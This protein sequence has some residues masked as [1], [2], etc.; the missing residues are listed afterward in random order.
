MTQTHLEPQVTKSASC[1]S[2]KTATKPKV[3]QLDQ[4]N[5]KPEAT[6]LSK[7]TNASTKGLRRTA[8]AMDLAMPNTPKRRKPLQQLATPPSSRRQN[9]SAR[10][11]SA[12]RI[13]FFE[14]QEN[15]VTP[16]PLTAASKTLK[17]SPHQPPTMLLTP[18]PT[19]SR[20][21]HPKVRAALMRAQEPLQDSIDLTQAT[22]SRYRRSV[23]S[24]FDDEQA[25]SPAK[26]TPSVP[27][28]EDETDTVGPAENQ[29]DTSIWKEDD[30]DTIELVSRP[31]NVGSGTAL[32][33]LKMTSIGRRPLP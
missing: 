14:R 25:T 9:H 6:V 23:F 2:K 7:P 15:V 33:K 17:S 8:T 19:P 18:E 29:F 24:I 5:I 11:T 3:A 16:E 12:E 32:R 31:F 28:S 10:K 4:E 22:P 1:A 21:V 27:D 26:E 20:R 13:A 30:G